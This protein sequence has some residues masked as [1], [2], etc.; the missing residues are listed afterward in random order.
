[1]NQ[2]ERPRPAHPVSPAR[3]RIA[4]VAGVVFVLAYIV[5][6]I[7]VPDW[8]GR[9]NW[10]AEA[11]YWLVAGIVWVFP[12]RWLLLWSVGKR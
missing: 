11:L 8:T 12:I 2:L 1:M 10:A 6:A 5:L 3:P 4:A 9:M 7:T